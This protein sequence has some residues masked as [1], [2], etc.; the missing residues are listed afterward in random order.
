MS[1]PDLHW[2]LILIIPVGFLELV[3]HETSHAVVM[4]LTGGTLQTFKPYPHRE[5]MADGSKRWWIGYVTCTFPHGDAP[6]SYNYSHIAPLITSGLLFL[7]GGALA[8]LAWF[9]LI[10][11]SIG[12]LIDGGNWLRGYLLQK[13]GLDGAKWR[14]W[15]RSLD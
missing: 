15:R 6:P 2:I 14:D 5:V 12:A 1:M 10:T 13:P 7:L 8:W 3:L 11:I 9:P 4:K